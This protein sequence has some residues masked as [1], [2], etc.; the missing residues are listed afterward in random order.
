MRASHYSSQSKKDVFVFFAP[1]YKASGQTYT[2]CRPVAATA[3]GKLSIILPDAPD[4]FLL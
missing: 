1:V 3:A 2:G 4:G